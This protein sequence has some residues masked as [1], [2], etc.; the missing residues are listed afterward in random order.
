MAT[1]L[2]LAYLFFLGSVLGWILEV[3]YRRFAPSNKTGKWVNPGFCVG[4]YLPIYGIA[5]CVLCSLAYIGTYMGWD[6]TTSGRIFLFAFMAIVITIIEY[7]AGVM[8]VKLFNVRLWD[9]RKEP[10]NIGGHICLKFT[11]YWWLLS[12]L[13]YFL[14]HGIID[15]CLTWLDAHLGFFFVVGYFFGIFT[16][17]VIYSGDLIFKMSDFA[18]RNGIVVA[19][20]SIIEFAKKKISKIENKNWASRLERLNARDV[21]NNIRKVERTIKD[22]LNCK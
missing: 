13:Y 3:F 8:C 7:F 1:P 11:F 14:I 6:K 5:V 9:Y 20:D 15:E 19:H 22:K 4:P 18:K 17:D 21:L 10:F 2:K 16:I 12:A